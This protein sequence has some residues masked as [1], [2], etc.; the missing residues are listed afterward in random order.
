MAGSAESGVSIFQFKNYIY[1]P[2]FLLLQF[3][4]YTFQRGDVEDPALQQEVLKNFE[5]EETTQFSSLVDMLGVDA[6][7]EAPSP[8]GNLLDNGL[9]DSAFDFLEDYDAKE[10]QE[11]F[12]TVPENE[13]VSGTNWTVPE[14]LRRNCASK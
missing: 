12:E 8:E 7:A 2:L 3:A 14:P 4:V 10:I 9:F 5:P 13:I 11:Q 1:L 6:T